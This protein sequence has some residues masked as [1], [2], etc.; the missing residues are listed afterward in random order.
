MSRIK[1]AASFTALA[2]FIGV[3]TA[4]S[5]ASQT[6][7]KLCV[8]KTKGTVRVITGLACRSGET[9]IKVV[10]GTIAG[11]QGP[12]GDPGTNGAPGLPGNDGPQGPRGLQGDPG[13]EGPAALA[14]VQVIQ[15]KSIAPNITTQNFVFQLEFRDS[16]NMIMNGNWVGALHINARFTNA[17]SAVIFTCVQTDTTTPDPTPTSMY[18][19]ADALARTLTL[20]L[21][22]AALDTYKANVSCSAT[23]VNGDALQLTSW[24][25]SDL[26]IS[27]SLFR[28]NDPVGYPDAI[29]QTA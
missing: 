3:L 18:V 9:L 10:A 24:T 27:G 16:T 4:G 14:D 2:V 17:A 19:P 22:V 13:P 23:A 5:A 1:V 6:T 11:P 26:V 20:S 7:T 28:A 8:N 12:K 25:D 21:P 15:K 29:A